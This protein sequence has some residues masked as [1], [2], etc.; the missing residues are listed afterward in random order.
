MSKTEKHVEYFPNGKKYREET[1]KDGK[2]IEAT[3]WDEN[4]NEINRPRWL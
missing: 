2:E 3:Y 4:G 1:Y